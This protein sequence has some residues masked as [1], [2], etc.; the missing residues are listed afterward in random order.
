MA[1]TAYTRTVAAVRQGIDAAIRFF[2][3]RDVFLSYDRN[4]AVRYTPA[5][6]RRLRERKISV[7][8]DQWAAPSDAKLPARVKR[9]VRR[10]TV[11][12]VVVG[13]NALASPFVREEVSIFMPTLGPIVPI[14]GGSLERPAWMPGTVWVREP[15]TA[16]TNGTPTEPVVERIADTVGTMTQS[17]RLT[18]SVLLAIALLLVAGGTIWF[19]RSDASTQRVLAAQA[20]GERMRAKHDATL[21]RIQRIAA[22]KDAEDARTAREMALDDAAKA[23]QA[24]DVAREQADAAGRARDAAAND[25]KRQ[26]VVA[27][28]LRQ[29]NEA[30]T[31]MQRD[32]AG[33]P[34]AAVLAIRATQSLQS[35]NVRSPA[36]DIA[37]RDALR[38][39][40]TVERTIPLPGEDDDRIQLSQDGR[41][42]AVESPT[43]LRV[44]NTAD[45]S[46]RDAVMEGIT[47]K[48][49]RALVFSADGSA[50]AAAFVNGTK[51]TVQ[52]WNSATG[53]PRCPVIEQSDPNAGLADLA[54]PSPETLTTRS[55]LYAKLMTLALSPDGKRLATHLG[56]ELLV[57]DAETGK[58]ASRGFHAPRNTAL[59]RLVFSNTGRFLA[60]GSDELRV[61]EWQI[62][63]EVAAES[64]GFLDGIESL[65]FRADDWFI[66]FAGSG[67]LG[68][69][70]FELP[71]ARG[72]WTS[73]VNATSAVAFSSSYLVAADSNRLAMFSGGDGEQYGTTTPGGVTLAVQSKGRL[74]VTGS[75]DG[76]ARLIDVVT[77]RELARAT[78][79]GPVSQ[80]VITNDGR[81]VTA[82]R[83]EAKVWSANGPNDPQWSGSDASTVMAVSPDA[84]W[85]VTAH[86]YMGRTMGMTPSLLVCDAASGARKAA[87][88]SRGV[89]SL[90]FLGSDRILATNRSKEL[91]LWQ[92]RGD[93]LVSEEVPGHLGRADWIAVARDGRTLAAANGNVV[94][95]FSDWRDPSSVTTLTQDSPVRTLAFDPAGTRLFVGTTA[96]SV[97]VWDGRPMRTPNPAQHLAHGAFVTS[98]AYYDGFL[99][100]AGGST[101]KV[102]NLRKDASAPIA[103]VR[104]PARVWSVA[105][106]PSGDVLAVISADGL[107]RIWANW[108]TATPEEIATIRL[109]SIA[110]R[111]ALQV[112]FVA[113]G[114]L[115]VSR[116]ETAVQAWLWRPSELLAQACNRLARNVEDGR[117]RNICGGPVR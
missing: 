107:L 106:D 93:Q 83:R 96:G 26:R 44:I 108:M 61:W 37:L 48:S 62:P 72:G 18:A 51:W 116:Q 100:S 17:Q 77:R 13:R 39:L 102:W 79:P 43:G 110:E 65:A 71:L 11:L 70:R 15:D 63:K 68:A 28:A 86:S 56:D 47:P 30:E 27:E 99:V 87:G 10:S 82:S 58:V 41:F 117:W 42:I 85:V 25:A 4:D 114:R 92:W 59:V 75:M 60:A 7:Y 21:A 111:D 112:A 29:S 1:R 105:I 52:V 95:V 88:L 76:T 19:A 46:A 38:L 2:F 64:T 101:A 84:R 73:K 97:S 50:V 6:A 3:G 74:A 115:L 80:V 23:S 90:A 55:S 40:P 53:E 109:G 104:S 81:V 12:V 91:L 94:R 24:R 32:P 22:N 66:A 34:E 57:W 89:L 33:I 103:T 31:L 49:L 8:I 5:L 35:L 98:L 36:A 67:Y 69:W 16:I 78:H 14:L 54:A 20:G 113:D 45:G 9:A